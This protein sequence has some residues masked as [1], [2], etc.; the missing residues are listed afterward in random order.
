MDFDKW[1]VQDQ[2][3]IAVRALAAT[4]ESHSTSPAKASYEVA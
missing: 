3:G 4:A 2:A 1:V